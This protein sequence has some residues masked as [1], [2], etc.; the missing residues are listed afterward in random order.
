MTV[1]AFAR[2]IAR[3]G[4]RPESPV[5]A[6]AVILVTLGL[7]AI[8]LAA[9]RGLGWTG[10]RRPATLLPGLVLALSLGLLH[11]ALLPA[12]LRMTHPDQA[13][14]GLWL[15][16]AFAL[17]WLAVGAALARAGRREGETG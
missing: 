15:A 13:R 5:T 2:A 7:L 8:G 9:W 4:L 1:H 11:P 3:P 17:N 16:A 12:V 14:L 6:G 10:W